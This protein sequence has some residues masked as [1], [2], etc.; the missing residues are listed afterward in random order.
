M[1]EPP[2]DDA[3]S[4]RAA[5]ALRAFLVALG[6]PVDADPELRDTPDRVARAFRDELLDG[7]RSEPRDALVDALPSASEALVAVTHVAYASV[8][9]HHMLPS[10]G[11]AHVGYLPG[12]RIVGL[13]SIVRLIE[14]CAHRM[15]LQETLG[16]RIADALVE[17][18][19]AR[20]AGVVLDASHTCMIAR[21]E[22]QHGA[23][24]VTQSF[25]G[26][27]RHDVAA[28]GELL[29]AVTLGARR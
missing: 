9:P 8:C 13:G 10:T 29:H 7:Y 17:H 28:R 5:E 26:A 15:V 6:L 18:L 14:I 1:R 22:R 3:P 12:G 4:P 21:G 2:S 11:V 27:W 23:P 25:A 16:Q 24:V 20:A 19:G